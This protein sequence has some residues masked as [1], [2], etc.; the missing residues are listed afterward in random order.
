MTQ[1]SWIIHQ[2]S[3]Q[4]RTNTANYNLGF[5]S[6]PKNP[7]PILTEL[8]IQHNMCKELLQAIY[9]SAVFINIKN[10]FLHVRVGSGFIQKCIF[11]PI[12]RIIW[13]PTDTFNK[14]SSNQ[15]NTF[16]ES[17]IQKCRIEKDTELLD[18]LLEQFDF[19]LLENLAYTFKPSLPQKLIE[20]QSDMGIDE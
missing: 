13:E 4:K 12:L 9:P 16:L 2:R 8:W 14:I 6:T 10:D 1:E 5:L 3:E 7:C 18:Q 20:N 17:A 15:V 11:N 19:T